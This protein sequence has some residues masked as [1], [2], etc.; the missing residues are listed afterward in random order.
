VS[1][2]AFTTPSL[3]AG[4]YKIEYSSEVSSTGASLVEVRVRIDATTIALYNLENDDDFPSLSGFYYTVLTAG[5]RTVD[6]F[7]RVTIGGET[8]FIRRARI[9]IVR[10]A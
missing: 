4:T 2:V 8:A 5:V 3:P 9:S 1:K 6:M 10:V 7:Y